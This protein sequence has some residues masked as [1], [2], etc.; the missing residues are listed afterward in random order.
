MNYKDWYSKVVN[1]EQD[2]EQPKEKA[3]NGMTWQEWLDYINDP[4]RSF[5]VAVEEI[6]Y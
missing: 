3:Y 4:R 2:K 1:K 5:E 6:P